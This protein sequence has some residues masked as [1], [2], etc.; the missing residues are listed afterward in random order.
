MLGCIT[1]TTSKVC[2]LCSSGVIV[3]SGCSSVI[4]CTGVDSSQPSSPCITC[5]SP[6][7]LNTPIN[8]VC[9][10]AAGQLAGFHCTTMIG[11]MTADRVGGK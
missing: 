8:G 1:C 2:T 11:C 6:E 9:L 3:N 7:F 5:D 10:C 4:G